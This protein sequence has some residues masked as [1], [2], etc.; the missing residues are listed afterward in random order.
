VLLVCVCAVFN[1]RT[2]LPTPS[3]A[4]PWKRPG[5]GTGH[6]SH[7][8][9]QVTAAP[10]PYAPYQQEQEHGTFDCRGLAKLSMEDYLSAVYGPCAASKDWMDLVFFYACLPQVVM[11]RYPVYLPWHHDF[12]PPPRGTLSPPVWSPACTFVVTLVEPSSFWSW[13]GKRGYPDGAAVEA[14]HVRDD[15]PTYAVEGVWLYA[16][17]GSGVKFDVGKSLRAP[18]KLLAF[19]ALGMSPTDVGALVYNPLGDTRAL[20]DIGGGYVKVADTALSHFPQPAATDASAAAVAAIAEMVRTLEGLYEKGDTRGLDWEALYEIDRTNNSAD[21]DLY[22]VPMAKSAGYDSIQF[23]SQSNGCGG[24]AVGRRRSS[25]W[26]R[27]SSINLWRK[28]G[29]AGRRWRRK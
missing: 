28:N 10:G 16:G 11:D 13:P 19:R 23:T 5:H 18:C 9:P 26:A 6:D 21:Y 22:L 17:S 24:W 27:R 29:L 4:P 15:N 8:G 7:G 2:E 12:A 20:P 25:S 14:F 3:P 1:Q